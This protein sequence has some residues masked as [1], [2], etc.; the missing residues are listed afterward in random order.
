MSERVQ[1]YVA[2]Q[3]MM[4]V[5]MLADDKEPEAPDAMW[6][7]YA[8]LLSASREVETLHKRI[9]GLA[10]DSGAVQTDDPVEDARRGMEAKEETTEKWYLEADSLRCEL[11]MAEAETTKQHT[12]RER[13]ER[14]V[15]VLRGI[16]ATH[17]VPAETVAA[18]LSAARAAK[19]AHDE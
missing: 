10:V 2:V 12:A 8:A 14:E 16:C 4:P 9:R 18:A 13:A 1:L 5:L 17:G 6:V 7:R 3:E 15:E 19:E 11:S